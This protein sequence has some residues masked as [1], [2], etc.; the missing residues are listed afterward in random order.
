MKTYKVYYHDREIHF[1]AD[2]LQFSDNY[3]LFFKDG[4][5]IAYVPK[6][7]PFTVIGIK[8]NDNEK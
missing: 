4:N 6:S 2:D 1:E 3:A 8:P 5:K 7:C